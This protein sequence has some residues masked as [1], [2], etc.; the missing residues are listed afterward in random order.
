MILSKLQMFLTKFNDK[1][2]VCCHGNICASSS[3]TSFKAKTYKET[4][5]VDMSY[6]LSLCNNI[7]EHQNFLQ[8]YVSPL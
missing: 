7:W 3:P 6:F 4:E 2:E 1:Y 8:H 5:Y